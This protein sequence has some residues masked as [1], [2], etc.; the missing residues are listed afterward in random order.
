MQEINQFLSGFQN[1]YFLIAVAAA[2]FFLAKAITG[3]I[4]YRHYERKFKQIDKKLDEL[5]QK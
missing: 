1:N 4:T 3:Y 2:L 5:L